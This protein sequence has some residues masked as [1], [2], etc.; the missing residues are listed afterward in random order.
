MAR[1]SEMGARESVE[2]LLRTLY[3]SWSL[4]SL[5]C[6]L[7]RSVRFA[8]AVRIIIVHPPS[9]P[10]A[11]GCDAQFGAAMISMFLAIRIVRYTLRYTLQPT[12]AQAATREKESRRA[13]THKSQD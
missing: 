2:K 1:E 3:C 13:R 6:R 5:D 7:S 10:D 8:M 11:T 4:C 12:P 9:M